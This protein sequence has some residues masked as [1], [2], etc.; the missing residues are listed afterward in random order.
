[1]KAFLNCGKTWPFKQKLLQTKSRFSKHLSFFFFK[2]GAMTIKERP[3]SFYIYRAHTKK[4]RK[5]SLTCFNL[6]LETKKDGIAYFDRDDDLLEH[7]R[8]DNGNADGC[9]YDL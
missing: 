5:P 6:F 3:L 8:H 2:E 4:S 1:M 7:H 9:L